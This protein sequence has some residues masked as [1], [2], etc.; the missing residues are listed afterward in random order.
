MKKRGGIRQR[1]GGGM[2]KK[3]GERKGKNKRGEKKTELEE[4]VR[5]KN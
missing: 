5:R 3:I 4:M 1:E 2:L